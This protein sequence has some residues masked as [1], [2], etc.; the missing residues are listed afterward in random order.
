M[1]ADVAATGYVR[2]VTSTET[3]ESAEGLGEKIRRLRLSAGVSQDAL[4]ARAAPLSKS[5]LSRIENGHRGVPDPTY[6]RIVQALAEIAN[7]QR[8]AS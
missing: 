8:A 3:T 5:H 1:L 6:Q 2:Q 4:V 7:E